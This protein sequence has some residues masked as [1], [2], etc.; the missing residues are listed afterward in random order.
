MHLILIQLNRLYAS[1]EDVKN[2]GHC[3][4]PPLYRWMS[5][6]RNIA[7]NSKGEAGESGFKNCWWVCSVAHSRPVS[8][9]WLDFWTDYN[10]SEKLPHIYFGLDI[11]EKIK[12]KVKWGISIEIHVLPPI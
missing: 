9:G 4:L 2:R 1:Q 12:T 8:A 5:A 11:K 6:T 3:S 7:F 10:A